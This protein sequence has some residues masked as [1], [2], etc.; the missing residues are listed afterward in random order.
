MRISELPTRLLALKYGADLVW[1]PEVVDKALISGEMCKRIMNEKINCIE[2]I[3][4]PKN[5]VLYRIH[6]MEK[7][8]LIFQLGSADPELA[9]KAAKIIANDV[10]AVDLNCG[11]PKV[12]RRIVI[13]IFYLFLSIFLFIVEW[14]QLY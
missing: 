1:G 13:F 8:R 4:P 14:V 9:V 7:S 11:C 12:C 3:K 10:A 5:T 6:P 2:F